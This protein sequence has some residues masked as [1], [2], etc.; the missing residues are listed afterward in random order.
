MYICSQERD[1]FDRYLYVLRPEENLC[2]TEDF[3]K[4]FGAIP[5]S[6]YENL[7][8]RITNLIFHCGENLNEVYQSFFSTEYDTFEEFLEYEE[9]LHED[10]VKKLLENSKKR[11]CVWRIN[12]TDYETY[13]FMN[14]FDNNVWPEES[15]LEKVNEIIMRC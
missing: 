9:C 5:N 11:E 1:S 12:I 14:L 15:L 4:A 3:V 8:K 7:V 13:N 10:M 6:E 2:N